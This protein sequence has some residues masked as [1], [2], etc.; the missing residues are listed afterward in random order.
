M[1]PAWDKLIIEYADSKTAGVY[2]VDCTDAGKDLCETHG[3]EGFPTIKYG[4]PSDL[5]DY[6]GGRDFD[7][8]KKFAKENLKPV[9]SVVNI[10]LCDDAKKKQIKE[11]QSLSSDKLDKLIEEKIAEEKAVSTTF[12]EEVEKL[13]KRYEQ[14]EEEKKDKLAKIKDSGL[15]LMKAVKAAA[16]SKSEL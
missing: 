5:Q 16:S 6:E 7:E 9:C 2:D 4:D 1:K 15:G 8:L 13:Q 14:L 12:E 10:D 3:V 11:F